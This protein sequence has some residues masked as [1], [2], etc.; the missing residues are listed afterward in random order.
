M[1]EEGFRVL[2]QLE[3][4]YNVWKRDH[5]DGSTTA[6]QSPI[7]LQRYAESVSVEPPAVLSGPPTPAH[8]AVSTGPLTSE[9]WREHHAAVAERERGAAGALRILT[10]RSESDDKD[11][12]APRGG[13]MPPIKA[14]TG[15]A[16]RDDL[17]DFMCWALQDYKRRARVEADY[18]ADLWMATTPLHPIR[19]FI[20]MPDKKLGLDGEGLT[21]EQYAMVMATSYNKA[22]LA[23][24]AARRP[25]APPTK[26]EVRARVVSM[27]FDA[28]IPNFP[29]DDD[30]TAMRDKAQAILQDRNG[31]YIVDDVME[32]VADMN[33]AD[34][35]LA[36]QREGYFA[37]S[38]A[39]KYQ[40][41]KDNRDLR[42]RFDSAFEM[43]LESA[44]DLVRQVD[45]RPK[46]VIHFANSQF[47][48][49]TDMKALTWYVNYIMA[50]IGH[51]NQDDVVKF[52]AMRMKPG[53]SPIQAYSRV[54]DY[55]QLI[56][57]SNVQG[58]RPEQE[59]YDLITADTGGAEDVF[60]TRA[61]HKQVYTTVATAV[62]LDPKLNPDNQPAMVELWVDVAN[63]HFQKAHA[64]KE[65]LYKEIQQ[66]CERR[67]R[68]PAGRRRGADAAPNNGAAKEARGKEAAK[69]QASGD[70]KA[71]QKWCDNHKWNASHTTE[72]CRLGPEAAAAAKTQQQHA[73]KGK[74][75]AQQAPRGPIRAL[76][77]TPQPGSNP[78]NKGMRPDAKYAA[79]TAGAGPS[80]RPQQQ[81]YQ[82]RERVFCKICSNIAGYDVQHQLPCFQDGYSHIPESY[83]P[84]N[85]KL[86]ARINQLRREKGLPIP[87]PPQRN[88][89]FLQPL[90]SEIIYDSP[91]YD[92]RD[93]RRGAHMIRRTKVDSVVLSEAAS[94][95]RDVLDT[96][97]PIEDRL[98]FNG[99]R[100]LFTCKQD[101]LQCY[102][103]CDD[104]TGAFISCKCPLCAQVYTADMMPAAWVSPML[105]KHNLPRDFPTM[106]PNK[107]KETPKKRK[108]ILTFRQTAFERPPIE[109]PSE[110]LV[111]LVMSRTLLGSSNASNAPAVSISSGPTMRATPEPRGGRQS[112]A[113]SGQASAAPRSGS[114]P[115]SALEQ[116]Q[117]FENTQGV[118]HDK[119]RLALM[120]IREDVEATGTSVHLHLI[121][122]LLKGLSPA[123]AEKTHQPDNG[124]HGALWR[125]YPDPAASGES[126]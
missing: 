40:Y 43:E 106:M 126:D 31:L 21:P 99:L 116:G 1:T 52:R 118:L 103:T 30:I 58:F 11:R 64:E 72:Q 92:T 45:E 114:K 56:E 39:D 46:E 113:L 26:G 94:R 42:E 57:M 59:M 110:T 75:Q 38:T 35:A 119:N 16:L 19:S 55:C 48:S 102:N 3:E 17:M 53:E 8:S 18:I 4:D 51:V 70:R 50:K 90:A 36:E 104:I 65:G 12:A 27:I 67:H 83:N 61:M 77:T 2:D 124:A 107:P 73:G 22:H 89:N 78:V 96:E 111:P 29:A 85:A 20:K 14:H 9:D 25:P 37:W 28:E 79:G 87:P 41:I 121:E 66:E 123:D 88:V 120:A 125:G 24:L 122:A 6:P 32:A 115:L 71:G 68:N 62:Y 49:I 86:R 44:Q 95:A 93:D 81:Q 7:P 117:A 69:P 33:A 108:D 109:Y 105:W 47:L 100:M 34:A 82:P 23:M 74:G 54:R 13:K 60:F 15:R 112:M 80:A 101:D 5:P 97:L 98:E 76:T 10:L 84:I 91:V 63:T